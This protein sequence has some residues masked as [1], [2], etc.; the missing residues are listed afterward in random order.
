MAWGYNGKVRAAKFLEVLYLV[1]RD[2]AR[3]SDKLFNSI[4][5]EYLLVVNLVR[6]VLVM[7]R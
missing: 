2:L 1:G 6:A 7:R 4:T 5:F 3:E